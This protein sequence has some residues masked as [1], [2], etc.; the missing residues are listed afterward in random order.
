M[1]GQPKVFR[2]A[3]SEVHLGVTLSGGELEAQSQLPSTRGTVELLYAF[4]RRSC[5]EPVVVAQ[6]KNFPTAIAALAV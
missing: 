3:D 5:E 2:F 4:E 1:S 6:R